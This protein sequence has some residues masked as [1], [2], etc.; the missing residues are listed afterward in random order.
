MVA[1][2]V[3]SESEIAAR[4]AAILREIAAAGGLPA[5][6]ADLLSDSFGAIGLNSVDY[7]EFVL[8]VESELNIDVPDEALMDPSLR[9]VETWAAWLAENAADLATPTV[10]PKA[11]AAAG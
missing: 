6:D 5:S 1:A 4:L 11:E 2:D 8:N 10:E 7:L 9:S 3:P